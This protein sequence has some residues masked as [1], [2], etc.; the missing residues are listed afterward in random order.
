[1]LDIDVFAGT[2]YHDHLQ[3]WPSL[4]ACKLACMQHMQTASSLLLHST[5]DCVWPVFHPMTEAA[6]RACNCGAYK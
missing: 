2:V 3:Y 4:H 6:D 5:A 1:M